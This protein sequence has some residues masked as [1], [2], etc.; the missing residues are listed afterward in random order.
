M[1]KDVVRNWQVVVFVGGWLW[2][3]IARITLSFAISFAH[4][5]TGLQLLSRWWFQSFFSFL[6]ARWT[7]FDLRIFFPGGLVKNPP[8]RRPAFISPRGRQFPFFHVHLVLRQ[9][10]GW[11]SMSEDSVE[12]KLFQ[13]EKIN[14]SHMKTTGLGGGFKTFFFHLYLG[15]IPILTNIFQLGWNHQLVVVEGL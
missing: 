1:I 6:G 15:K 4:Y 7:H 2:G 12:V 14:I 3:S 10:G 9:R 13:V 5:G 11:R 8:T